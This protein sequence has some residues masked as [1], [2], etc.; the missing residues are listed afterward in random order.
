[1]S[2]VDVTR[3]L[4]S[5][6][7]RWLSRDIGAA[8]DDDTD[9]S[10][11]HMMAMHLT[12]PIEPSREWCRQSRARL[13]SYRDAIETW[14]SNESVTPNA[15]VAGG[16]WIAQARS[17]SS[18]LARAAT[19]GVG[20]CGALASD[21]VHLTVSGRALISSSH[22]ADVDWSLASQAEC[23]RRRLADLD[24]TTDSAIVALSSPWI[25]CIAGGSAIGVYIPAAKYSAVAH[26]TV[27][28]S[29]MSVSLTIAHEMIHAACPQTRNHRSPYVANV[30][31]LLDEAVVESLA[32]EIVQAKS[33]GF[34]G[35]ERVYHSYPWY[36]MV[37]DA[38]QP[39]V[40]DRT[41]WLAELARVG[42]G[43]RVAWLADELGTDE[44][45]V[46]QELQVLG[47]GA[48]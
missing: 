17:V 8:E 4:E 22:S 27:E 7:H 34:V 16:K 46:A 12:T 43:R 24:I 30:E 13:M 32:G 2:T 35:A 14:A 31:R 1:M 20:R 33:H 42:E 41:R 36:V 6:A 21:T 11:A 18:R 28:P 26:Y 3:L 38:V 23:V 29:V 48:S 45:T 37:M 25:R 44:L 10:I 19:T 5:G 39:H 9:S 15:L 40:D 47:L